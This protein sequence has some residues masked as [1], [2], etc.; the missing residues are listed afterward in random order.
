[1]CEYLKGNRCKKTNEACPYVYF[2][3]KYNGYRPLKSMPENC[4]VKTPKEKVKV[5][6]VCYPVVFER[7]GWLHIDVKGVLYKI[8]N[9][10]NIVP[11]YVKL[12]KVEGE[13]VIKG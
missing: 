5:P 6:R 7:K 8:R 12:V 2:C 1:M 9:P 3:K 10:F 4:S 13:W 11:P